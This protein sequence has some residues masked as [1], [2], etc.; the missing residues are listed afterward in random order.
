MNSKGLTRRELLELG[1]VGALLASTA[2]CAGAVREI[3]HMG[4]LSSPVSEVGGQAALGI[5]GCRDMR[6]VC[7]AVVPLVSDMSWLSPGDSVLI[8]V[9]CNSD[10]P[11]PAVTAPDAV[12]AMVGFL[13]DRGAG[14]IYVGDQAGVEHVRLTRDGRVHC[15]QAVMAKNGLREAVLESGARLICFDDYGWEG[16][17]QPDLDF[18]D[19]WEGGLWIAEIVR[20]VDHIINLPR[21][22]T[23]SLAGY[24]CGLKNAVGWLRDDSRRV[25]HQRGGT[26]FEKMAEINHARPIRDRLRLTLTLATR[27]LL[28]IGP[29]FGG[30]YDF[31]GCLALASTSLVDHDVV[32]AALLPWLDD[33]DTSFFDIYSPY[34]DHADHWNR[35]LVRETWG[36]SAMESYQPILPY[37]LAKALEFD[38][39]AS[40]LAQLQRYRPRRISLVRR[41][42][43]IPE[44]LVAYLRRVAGGI[45]AV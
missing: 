1:A 42:E 41:G 33:H 13:R 23:H 12:R 35:W 11:H 14:P 16:Y 21:L 10:N 32:A 30:E 45:L 27:A 31:G 39:C 18:D 29:D 22:G 37:R 2:G 24:T 38:I 44:G 26:F 4:L 7:E 9:S 25:L 19:S 40:R 34:P 6:A 17:F 8:K 36:E 15:T 43:R 5:Y 3:P 28:N 20:R